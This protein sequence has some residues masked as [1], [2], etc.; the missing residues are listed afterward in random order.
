[1]EARRRALG[2]GL[3]ALI[4]PE[5][6]TTIAPTGAGQTP[7][8]VLIEAIS[9]NRYQPRQIFDSETLAD[10]S[11]SIKQKRFTAT[12]SRA[13]LSGPLRADRRGKAVSRR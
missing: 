2:R 6:P 4:A 7:T 10:L 1:M 12:P 8:T 3:G 9:P 13:R 5:R 11:R